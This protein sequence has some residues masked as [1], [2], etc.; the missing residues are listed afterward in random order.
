[1]QA[2]K[3]IEALQRLRGN[4][5]PAEQVDLLIQKTTEAI[6]FEFDFG[7]FPVF[8]QETMIDHV[9]KLR[10]PFPLCYFEIPGV[11]AMLARESDNDNDRYILIHPFIYGLFGS[12]EWGTWPLDVILAIDKD[13]GSVVCLSDDKDIQRDFEISANDPQ[14]SVIIAALPSMVIRGLSVMNCS[15]VTCVENL[16]PHAL[17]KKRVKNGKVPMFSYKTLHISAGSQR[18]GNHS[19]AVLSGRTGPRLHL[20]RGHI[21]RLPSGITTWVQPCMV[22]EESRGVVIKDYHVSD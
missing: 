17:N 7:E 14:H 21:R 12:K 3:V 22:G 16:P 19:D 15:N 10:L 1:M 4:P 13:R 5:M 2:H 8:S 6:K 20:R 18:S 9:D 11:G